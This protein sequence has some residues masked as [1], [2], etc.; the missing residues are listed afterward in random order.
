VRKKAQIF[1]KPDTAPRMMSRGGY[2]YLEKKLI[3][4]KRKKKLEEAAQ[5]RS[6]DTAIDP[7][8][9]IKQHVKWKLARTKKTSHM[10]SEAAKEI[11]DK[12]VSHF[13]FIIVIIFVYC[14]I[15]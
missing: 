8:S 11:A 1:Q 7:A 3:D 14:V 9:S 2:E 13:Q 5:S 4:E 10:T 6:I 15:E 12:I